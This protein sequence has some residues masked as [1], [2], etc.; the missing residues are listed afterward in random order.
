M[1]ARIAEL[2]G[3]QVDVVLNL[4]DTLRADFQV[5]LLTSLWDGAYGSDVSERGGGGGSQG[6]PGNTSERETSPADPQNLPSGSQL[7]QQPT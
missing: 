6:G 4:I 1:V 2:L 3:E 7:E 5:Q